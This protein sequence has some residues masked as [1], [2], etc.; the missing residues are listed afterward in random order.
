MANSLH[1]STVSCPIRIYAVKVDFSKFKTDITAFEV[2]IGK[3]LRPPYVKHQARKSLRQTFFPP[4][5]FSAG[6]TFSLHIQYIDRSLCL[7]MKTEEII[8]NPD[9]LFRV[10]RREYIMVHKKFRIIIE[11]SR[12]TGTE[13]KHFV[14]PGESLELRPIADEIFRKCPRFRILVIGKTGVGKSSLLYRTFGVQRTFSLPYN[15]GDANIDYEFISPQNDKLVIHDSKGFE[16]GQEDNLKIVRD[17]IDR[18]RNMPSE[19]QLHVIWLCIQI[20]YASGRLLD[21]GTEE[22]LTLKHSGMLGNVPVIVVFTKYDR[23]TD[24]IERTLYETSLNKLSDQAIEELVKKNAE[25]ELQDICIRPLQQIAGPDIPHATVSI[26]IDYKETL[27]RLIQ[28]TEDCVDQDAAAVLTFIT[29]Q[30]S[31]EFMIKASIQVGKKRCW[32][33]L[34]LNKLFE[35][36]Q[37]WEYLHALHTDTVNLWNFYDPHYYLHSQEFRALMT[38]MVDELELTANTANTRASG[39]SGVGTILGILASAL[40]GPIVIPI[41]AGVVL[42]KWYCDVR[43]KIHPVFR[44]FMSYIV[45]LTVVLHTLRFVSERQ[46]LTRRVIKLAVSSYL[47]SPMYEKVLTWIQDYD[48]QLTTMEFMDL[49]SLDNIIEIIQCYSIDAA[50]MSELRE[51]IPPVG[52]LPDEPW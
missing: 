42:A 12:N 22:F 14:S 33:A 27:I 35:N 50:E 46:E 9:N 23:L 8:I 17:F 30:M 26:A 20:P 44:L 51:K 1:A 31:P 19:H 37:R 24:R 39:S 18:R 3:S 13:A 5:V 45:H 34:A 52:L 28:I 32:K 25:A 4:I 47:G 29:Q 36:R 43:N 16:P 38:N 49:D 48:R 15:P 40:P 6:D 2:W 21:T 10:W 41:V 7:E 11:F